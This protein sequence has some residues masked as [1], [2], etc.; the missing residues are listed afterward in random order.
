LKRFKSIALVLIVSF[1]I[2]LALENCAAPKQCAAYGEGYDKP[3][4]NLGKVKRR[5]RKKERLF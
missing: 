5:Q 1:G 4:L 3:D 2:S